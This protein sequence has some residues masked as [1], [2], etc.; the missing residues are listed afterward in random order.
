MCA[1]IYERCSLINGCDCQNSVF[2]KMS[3]LLCMKEQ[4]TT[5]ERSQQ[6]LAPL[7]DDQWRKH[8]RPNFIQFNTNSSKETNWAEDQRETEC[9]PWYLQETMLW[10]LHCYYYNSM[11]TNSTA[12]TSLQA[13]RLTK[14]SRWLQIALQYPPFK[15]KLSIKQLRLTNKSQWG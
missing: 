10:I 2:S 14:S 12:C 15:C 7:T 8:Q 5:T 4:Q 6:H 3:V 11:M 13:E 9:V 1:Q